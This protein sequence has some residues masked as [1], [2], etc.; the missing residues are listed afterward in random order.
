MI[1]TPLNS[2]SLDHTSIVQQ[3]YH[4]NASEHHASSFK[5]D[6]RRSSKQIDSVFQLG[7]EAE[8]IEIEEK[9]FKNISD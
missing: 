1:L 7:Y 8:M 4:N 2:N 5:Y 9:Q 6:S 3:P